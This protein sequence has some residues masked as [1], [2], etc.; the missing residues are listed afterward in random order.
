M[1]RAN[2]WILLLVLG[3]LGCASGSAERIPVPRE[4]IKVYYYV[5][6]VEGTLKSSPDYESAD[7]GPLELNER[8]E[9]LE[10]GPA[11]WFRVRT[12]DGHQGWIN[13]K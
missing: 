9:K 2:Y 11:G 13:E 7:V 6:A 4:E 10:L 12:Q 1:L 5:G 8:V 3:L